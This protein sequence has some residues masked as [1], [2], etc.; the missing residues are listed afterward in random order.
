MKKPSKKK[1]ISKLTKKKIKKSLKTTISKKKQS[2]PTCCVCGKKA[3]KRG[4]DTQWYCRKHYN[5]NF[6]FPNQREN[7]IKIGRNEKC[8]CGSG[9]KYKRCC[10]DLSK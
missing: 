10:G 9:K 1:P 3:T 2:G 4:T 5:L 6:P 8:P 7:I